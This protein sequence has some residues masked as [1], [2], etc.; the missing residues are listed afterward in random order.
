MKLNVIVD[1][2][3][4]LVAATTGPIGYPEELS[5]HITHIDSEWVASI[6]PSPGQTV[7]QIEVSDRLV[8]ITNVVE[9]HRELTSILR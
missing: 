9:F 1:E 8:E 5:S 7:H 4:N 2:G 6:V 3:G